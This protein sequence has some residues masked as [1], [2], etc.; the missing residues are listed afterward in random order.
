MNIVKTTKYGTRR[1]FYDIT[2]NSLGCRY[3]FNI[4]NR[5]RM[6]RIVYYLT[7]VATGGIFGE[8]PETWRWVVIGF[9]LCYGLEK[10]IKEITKD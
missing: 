8:Y 6:K 1:H 4:F 5:M 9:A 10:L 7:G 3:V 2:F